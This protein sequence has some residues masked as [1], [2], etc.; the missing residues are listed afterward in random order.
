MTMTV[1][2][3]G[4]KRR[5]PFRQGNLRLILTI[6]FL[7]HLH[8]RRLHIHPKML[9]ECY[10]TNGRTS[11]NHIAALILTALAL[12][13]APIRYTGKPLSLKPDPPLPIRKVVETYHHM[14]RLPTSNF[15][16]SLARLLVMHRL[17]L[18]LLVLSQPGRPQSTKTGYETPE[19]KLSSTPGMILIGQKII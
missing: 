4:R 3:R 9:H 11:W 15:C 16:R 5:R 12:A 17:A 10:S 2:G 8:P 7:R 14:H 18:A 13:L 19:D 1:V 6:Q